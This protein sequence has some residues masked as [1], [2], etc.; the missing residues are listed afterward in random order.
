MRSP[1]RVAGGVPSVDGA[2]FGREGDGR[3]QPA[4]ALHGEVGPTAQYPYRLH[5]RFW[6]E[7]H[8]VHHAK[9]ESEGT[10]LQS[11]IFGM[12]T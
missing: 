10:C 12:N 7:V 2:G 5:M 9:K 6:V 11:Q 8:D 1:F 4:K 3:P